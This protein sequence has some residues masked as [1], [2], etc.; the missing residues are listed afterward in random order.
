LVC[1]YILKP[2]FVLECK[3]CN[4]E[5]FGE[6]WVGRRLFV[7]GVVLASSCQDDDCGRRRPKEAIE[8]L[9]AWKR[10]ECEARFDRKENEILDRMKALPA[11]VDPDLVEKMMKSAASEFEK[12]S[13]PKDTPAIEFIGIQKVMKANPKSDY[14]ILKR[15][16]GIELGVGVPYPYNREDFKPRTPQ[17]AERGS[18]KNCRIQLINTK[19]MLEEGHLVYRISSSPVFMKPSYEKKIIKILRSDLDILTKWHKLKPFGVCPE[20]LMANNKEE[21]AK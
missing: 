2:P 11:D 12:L 5:A 21:G 8:G 3:P 4:A 16:D 13:C 20:C 1:G 7:N 19:H 6:K 9:P 15:S 14:V 18:E 17:Q 10:T